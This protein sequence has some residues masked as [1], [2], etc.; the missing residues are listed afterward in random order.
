MAEAHNLHTGL[1]LVL[2]LLVLVVLFASMA[3]RL[4][5]PFP[6]LLVVAGL[7]ISFIPNVPRIQLAPDLVF[8]VFL[9]P[10][11]YASAWQTDFGKFRASLLPISML[12]FGLV[13]FTVLGVA[14]FA[15][16]FITA[17]DFKAGFVLGAVVAAT[18]AV[19]ASSIAR[20]IGLPKR[21]LTILEGESLLN[22]AT[23]LLALEFALEL[24]QRGD[25]PSIGAG[26]IRLVWLVFGGIVIGLLLG[27]LAHK[28]EQ[29]VDD[30]PIEMVISIILPYSAYLAAEEVK[31]SGVLAVVACGL[32]LSRH[33][34]S[35]LSAPA[36]LELQSAWNALDFLLNG[37]VFVLIGLQLPYV[38]SGIHGYGIWT[39]VGYGLVFSLVL[40]VL[41]LVWVSPGAY[42]STWVRRMHH[43]VTHSDGAEPAWPAP[44]EVFVIGWT[45][46]RGVVALAAAISLP[47][48]LANGQPFAQRNLIIFLTFSTIL[49]TLVLQGLS[50]PAI[51]RMLG[52]TNAGTERENEAEVRRTI[53][54]EALASLRTGR[55]EATAEDE[56]HAYD[57]LIHLYTHQLKELDPSTG[58]SRED[59]EDPPENPRTRL[60]K[61]LLA[62][63]R[64][65]LSRLEQ[66]GLV[67]DEVVRKLERQMDLTETRF[68][69]T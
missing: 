15:D 12:A 57:D 27:V 32:Y 52:L 39:L 10:L 62:Q 16:R 20:A 66:E 25:H 68:R 41:R 22:D 36:R 13:A 9:P 14:E 30:G 19:A 50:L 38:L 44:R 33:R 4:K 35:L 63:E 26:A 53:L 34:S 8:L 64:V 42:V 46:M 7:V 43:R 37:L 18:D 47:D 60:R 2:F 67:D 28:L 54:E 45:G 17:L 24:L 58:E 21:V 56:T 55:D 11:L 29:Q 59:A 31:S 49:V 5:L 65:T 3:R 69:E 6:I 48:T 61:E 40:I 51:V 23:A 1:A